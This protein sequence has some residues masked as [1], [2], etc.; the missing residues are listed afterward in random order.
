MRA[1]AGCAESQQHS[2]VA[3]DVRL[4]VGQVEELGD[5]G[6]IRAAHLLVDLR[7]DRC[8]LDLGEPVPAEELGLEGEHEDPPQVQLAGH[9]QQPVD[10]H[11]PDAL[12][13]HL[14]VHRDGA[15]LA[16]VRP[17]D[18]QRAAPD[19][20]AVPL[21][22]PELLDPLVERD[23]VLLQQDPARVDVDERLD[24]GHIR[25]AGAAHHKPIGLRSQPAHRSQVRGYRLEQPI[26][27]CGVGPTSH[28]SG[29]PSREGR[30][31]RQRAD[32][33]AVGVGPG[34]PDR[35][36]RRRRPRNALAHCC[37]RH[38][39]GRGDHRPVRRGVGPQLRRS[40]PTSAGW[41]TRSRTRPSSAPR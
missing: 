41:P 33:V 24:R 1:D 22:D 13:L 19:E 4:D 18:V 7:G 17:Q 29:D 15:H 39:R 9:I 34:V 38:L 8:A 25:G 21:G 37:F 12:A 26:F 5:T 20:L 16:E 10:D 40:R 14:R 23:Q 28:R 30:E 35:V 32:R 2:R 31:H 11:V 36:V 3:E 27:C 6:V